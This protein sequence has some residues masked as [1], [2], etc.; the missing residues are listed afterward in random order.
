MER[1][2]VP[3]IRWFEKKVK[4]KMHLAERLPRRAE[5]A[6]RASRMKKRK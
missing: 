2:C 1:A 3:F 4:K 5:C 6:D